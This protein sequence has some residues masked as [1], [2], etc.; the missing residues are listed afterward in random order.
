MAKQTAKNCLL[1][2]GDGGTVTVT[3]TTIA[4]GVTGSTYTLTD[5]GSGFGAIAVGD[6]I[7]VTG[8]TDNDD[9]TAVVTVAAAGSLTFV[10]PVDPDT[11]LDVTP[12]AET[13]GDSVTVVAEKFNLLL[14]QKDTTYQKS[15]SEID[16]SDKTSGNWGSSLAGTTKMSVSASGQIVF[17]GST[18]GRHKTLSDAIDAG[19]S[20]NVR[21]VLNS[22]RDSYYGPFVITSQDGG[23]DDNSVN[24]FTFA[25]S[26]AARPVYAVFPA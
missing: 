12:V 14:G 7:T 26:N 19:T 25:L 17:D 9:F 5:S 24:G 1:Y 16:T 13:A 3:A 2:V 10:Q 6:Q 20:V 18:N 21:L 11:R 22:N 8:L 23:G 15:A 4:V